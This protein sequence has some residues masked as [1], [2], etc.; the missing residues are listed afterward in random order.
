MDDPRK[1]LRRLERR[2]RELEAEFERLNALLR[3]GELSVEEYERRRREIEREFIEVMDRIAQLRFI[4]G[5]WI[6]R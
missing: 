2:R 5:G 3:A 4:V 1:E 6:W